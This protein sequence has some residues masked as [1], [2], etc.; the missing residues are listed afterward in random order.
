M[1]PLNRIKPTTVKLFTD[2]CRLMD[3]LRPCSDAQP[4]EHLMR[5]KSVL[6]TWMTL[7]K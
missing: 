5:A 1:D 3:P 4:F 6:T 2:K 7:L